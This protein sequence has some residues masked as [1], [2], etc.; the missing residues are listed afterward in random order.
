MKNNR[1]QTGSVLKLFLKHIMLWVFTFSLCNT[2]NSGLAAGFSNDVAAI[3]EVA[4]SVLMLEV[5]N[6]LDQCIKTGSGFV[7]FNNSTL[8]TNFHV[9]KDGFYIIANTDNGAKYKISQVLCSNQTLDIA[10]LTFEEQ[11][12]IAPLPMY[13]GDNIFRGETVVAI[14]S[15]IGITNTVSKGNISAIYTDDDV[16]WI[17]F[18]A[19][20]SQGSSGGV[21]LNDDGV[22]IGITSAAY[23]HGENMNLAVRAI[24][25][26]AMYNSWDGVTHRFIN[27]PTAS[28]IDYTTVS[29]DIVKGLDN[30]SDTA[31]WTCPECSNINTSLFCVQCGKARPEWI[32]SCGQKNT[33][34]F[35]GR[36]G[37]SV[38]SLLSKFEQA[39]NETNTDLLA[40][41]RKFS[42]L[43]SFDSGTYET[44]VGTNAN[45]LNQV[46]N[47]YYTYGKLLFDQGNYSNAISAL[48][49]LESD[50]RDTSELIKKSYYFYGEE[51][52]SLERYDDASSAFL[53]A[54]DFSNASE[55][56]L[57]AFY[58][59]AVS[60]L[61]KKKYDEA[62]TA[63]KNAGSFGDA[64]DRILEPYYVQAEA[65][66]SAERYNEASEAFKK[67]GNY[68]DASKRIQ[69]P[70]YLQAKKLVEEKKYD[71]A[72][73]AFKKC[74]NYSDSEDIIK[75]IY[76]LKGTQCFSQNIYYDAIVYFKLAGDYSDAS[77]KINEVKYSQAI[78]LGDE[79]NYS[80]AIPYLWEAIDYPPA[81]IK[82]EEYNY[83]VG[84]SEFQNNMFVSA[85]THF[86][87]AGNYSDAQDKLKQCYTK[88]IILFVNTEQFSKAYITYTDAKFADITLDDTIVASPDD[89]TEISFLVIQTAKKMGFIKTIKKDET[90]YQSYHKNDIMKME[91]ALS[92]NEDGVIF[93]DE[94]VY[95]FNTI[96]PGVE[97][98]N[99]SGILEKLKDLGYIS[100][101]LPEEHSNY[102]K[103]YVSIVKKAEKDYGLTVNGLLTP[104]EQEF[105]LGKESPCPDSVKKVTA[106]SSKGAVSLSWAAVK[107]AI[108]YDVYRDHTKIATVTGTTYKDTSVQMGS[109]YVYS[110]SA[111]N[112]SRSS[113]LRNSDSV[114][115]DIVY[116]PVSAEEII[117]NFYAYDNKYVKVSG[118]RKGK[119]EWDGDDLYILAKKG[120][121]YIYL[122]C[123]G[124]KTWS[125]RGDGIGVYEHRNVTSISVTGTVYGKK[126]GYPVISVHYLNFWYNN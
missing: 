21:L 55:K 72:L 66:L 103:K 58:L 1:H 81:K 27:A 33:S 46:S 16:P 37:N 112:Y 13:C 8:V 74:K 126:N 47:C 57:E 73:V 78:S 96:Y 24:V 89:S 7:A 98:K 102:Q 85:I 95:I 82:Y 119:G 70:Y 5:Y 44:P 120:D 31:Q 80:E 101:K 14:G 29:E 6:A 43:E 118:L 36:C 113:P 79:G 106:K 32:C 19:P 123:A 97:S 53:K 68:S 83:K 23:T 121:N 94:L 108:K 30:L 4:N 52:L 50:Y 45:A 115:V 38:T 28:K 87:E 11:T 25:A 34:A 26:Q 49:L 40:A 10:I 61:S 104:I 84:L 99:V 100:G 17:Q 125:W 65:L 76:Y 111:C 54:G 124:Y 122:Y 93:L 77:M 90:G 69:E 3:N 12:E 20:I 60:L 56:A 42:E 63:F 88:Q 67:A 92:L 22:V 75:Q 15:P 71:D 64:Q 105:I 117:N 41:A 114:Y 59:Q 91:S 62:S 51:L 116:T 107:G 2:H 18:T 35:C 48:L 110:V 86:S 39:C 109:T 9:I